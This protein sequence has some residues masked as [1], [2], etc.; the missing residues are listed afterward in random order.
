MGESLLGCQRAAAGQCCTSTT[1][2][3][4]A[5]AA[6]VTAM[7]ALGNLRHDSALMGAISSTKGK[8]AMPAVVPVRN[9]SAHLICC[10]LTPPRMK[11]CFCWDQWATVQCIRLNKCCSHKPNCSSSCVFKTQHPDVDPDTCPPL[12]QR[13][14]EDLWLQRLRNQLTAPLEE[15]LKNS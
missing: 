14:K 1:F 5:P 8:V 3:M 11:G 13:T 12:P 10:M 7:G 4:V 15:A 2:N 6:A 9:H